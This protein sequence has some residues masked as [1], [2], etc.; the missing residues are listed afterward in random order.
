MT[1][2]PAVLHRLGGEGPPVLLVHGFGADRFGWAANAHALMGAHTVWAV[3]LPGHGAAGNEVG[4]GTPAALAEGL[5]SALAALPVPLP[6]VAHSL[7]AAVVLHLAAR[8]PGAFDRLILIAP[9]GLGAGLD[10][11]FLAQ[12]PA[13]ATAEEAEALLARL[14]ERPRLVAPMAAHVR[15]GLAD[16]ARRAAL[17]AIAAALPAAGPPPEAAGAVTVLWGERDRIVPPP[18]GRVLGVAPEVIPGVGHLPHVEAAQAVNRRLVALL[19]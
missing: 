9:A 3:D 5:A 10:T 4:A 16:P 8:A 12:F 11:G 2:S 13:L 15:A 17:A 1:V 19:A 6:V 7:G 14:V 18:P